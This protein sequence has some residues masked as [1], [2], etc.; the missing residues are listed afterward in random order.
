MQ[1]GRGTKHPLHTFT[2]Q[3]N[4]EG[5]PQWITVQYGRGTKH[6]LHTF[7]EQNNIGGKPQWITVQYGRGTKHPLHT[8]TEQNNIGGKPQWITVQYGRGTKHPSH[9]FFCLW[10]SWICNK[11]MVKRTRYIMFHD[12][13]F[14]QW[15]VVYT[16]GLVTVM[17]I[18]SIWELSA[19]IIVTN[20][21]EHNL[22]SQRK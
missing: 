17:K 8:F 18:S 19:G 7:T 9:T 13:I 14:K 2:E 4:I 10:R 1:Y 3:N 22:I 11:N 5:K 15:P 12:G 21:V 20:L 6:P 16:P